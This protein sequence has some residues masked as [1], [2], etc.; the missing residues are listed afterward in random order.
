VG[1]NRIIGWGQKGVRTGERGPDYFLQPEPAWWYRFQDTKT[2]LPF[3]ARIDG[4]DPDITVG[5]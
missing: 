4:G 3:R 1:S 2:V 5:V